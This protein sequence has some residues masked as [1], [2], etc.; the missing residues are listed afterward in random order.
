MSSSPADPANRAHAI[1]PTNSRPVVAPVRG[2]GPGD[3]E[4]PWRDV[5]DVPD[6]TV[7]SDFCGALYLK[8][9]GEVI[10]L[11]ENGELFPPAAWGPFARVGSLPK[12]VRDACPALGTATTR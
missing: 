8:R 4:A 9:D 10:E 6:G 11:V 5:A 7:F 1:P 3:D 2:R 12:V